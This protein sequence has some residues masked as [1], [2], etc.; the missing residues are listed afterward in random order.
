MLGMPLLYLCLALLSSLATPVG[1]RRETADAYAA[2]VSSG[3]ALSGESA[4]G[5]SW[6]AATAG[7]AP[8]ASLSQELDAAEEALAAA[9]AESGDPEAYLRAVLS[10]A[11]DAAAAAAE[12]GDGELQEARDAAFIA[13]LLRETETEEGALYELEEGGS[14]AGGAS[15]EAG[16]EEEGAAGSGGGAA[17]LLELSAAGASAADLEKHHGYCEICASACALV[18]PQPRPC[19][20]AAG[21]RLHAAI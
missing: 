21:A 2:D 16:E 4:V 12:A 7:G 11:G 8:P 20:C 5:E 18:A 19:C 9:A 17:A 14:S 13:A 6:A 15:G 10:A 3:F 1:G